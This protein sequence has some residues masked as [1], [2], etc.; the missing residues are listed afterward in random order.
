MLRVVSSGARSLLYPCTSP[1]RLPHV[2]PNALL[3]RDLAHHGEA[4]FASITALLVAAVRRHRADSP[5]RVDPHIAGFECLRCAHGA[6]DVAGDHGSG[7]PV[8][9]V[10]GQRQRFGFFFEGQHGQNRSE[11]LLTGDLHR[12]LH[13]VENG[14][15]DEVP[16]FVEPLWIFAA[17]NKLRIGFAAVDVADDAF[18]L[19]GRDE[20]AHGRRWIHLIAEAHL[21]RGFDHLLKYFVVHF[22]VQ[23]QT[24]ARGADLSLVAKN[25]HGGDRGRLINRCVLINDDGAFAAELEAYG[26]ERGCGFRRD[27]FTGDGAT[28][29][30]DLG[31]HVML[32]QRQSGDAAI[33][34]HD[35]DDPRRNTRLLAEF[36]DIHDGETRLLRWFENHGVTSRDGGRDLP[37]RLQQRIVPGN[38]AADDTERLA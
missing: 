34:W 33:A 21:L 25:G 16:L 27:T 35:V 31:D 18:L 17:I 15:A 4:H 26:L 10:I 12:V 11:N 22:F 3:L 23:E 36:A 8:S 28:S 14:R 19:L 38:D 9:T 5:P 13:S 29:E 6:S 7:E 30:H 32:H 20:R 37:D 1:P 24:R 2:H